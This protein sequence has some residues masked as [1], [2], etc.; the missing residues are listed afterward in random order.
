MHQYRKTKPLIPNIDVM[1]FDH[2][3]RSSM[4][5]GNGRK[6][7]DTPRK[8]NVFGKKRAQETV[9]E[10]PLQQMSNVDEPSSSFMMHPIQNKEQLLDNPPIFNNSPQ[11]FPDLNYLSPWHSYSNGVGTPIPINSSMI[12]NPNLSNVPMTKTYDPYDVP[13]S[14][15]PAYFNPRAALN[16]P[17]REKVNQWIENVPIHIVH[18][19]YLTHDCYSIDEY[20]NWE[21]DEF[22]MSL[23]QRGEK[24]QIN[25]ATVDEL[26]QFQLKRITSMVLRLY[27]ESPEVPL[28]N[29]D[30]TSY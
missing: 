19:E 28:D 25:M 13:Q 20:M 24:T 26:L 30:A 22:D 27:E 8:D 14:S 29:S 15:F 2:D 4:I 16:M 21:E 11:Y 17:H 6:K 23:F 9:T 3:R 12:G 18:E 7:F 10:T 1:N 5:A